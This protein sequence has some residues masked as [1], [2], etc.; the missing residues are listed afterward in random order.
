MIDSSAGAASVALD[1]E[2]ALTLRE[3]K[4]LQPGD[5]VI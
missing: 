1:G 3:L 4:T 2:K 5:Y